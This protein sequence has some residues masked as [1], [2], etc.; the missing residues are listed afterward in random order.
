MLFTQP[1]AILRALRDKRTP[2]I[3]R[4]LPIF[5]LIYVFFPLDFIPDI[6]PF[7]GQIDDITLAFSII[8]YA[9]SLV[10]EEVLR[11]EGISLVRAQK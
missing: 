3:A 6:I 9:L 5:A 1:R 11:S 4:I 8:M 7:L 10:P 2:F